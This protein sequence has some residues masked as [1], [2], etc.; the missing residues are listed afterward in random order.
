MILLMADIGTEFDR[1]PLK[2]AIAMATEILALNQDESCAPNESE[3]K[4]IYETYKPKVSGYLHAR[5]PCEADADD[6]VHDVFEKIY[7]KY[8]SFDSRKASISTWV[9]T[10]TRNTLV[11]YLRRYRPWEELYESIVS[12]E[13]VDDR[14]MTDELLDELAKALMLLPTDQKDLIVMRYCDR[15]P[16]TEI[17]ARID[18]S[19]G[20]V[21]IIHNKAL[22]TLREAMSTYLYETEETSDSNEEIII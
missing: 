10:I 7:K 6:L 14:L 11:D 19:Y 4:N 5:V 22:K 18:R 1:F 2:G 17:S 13:M 3:L 9:F 21:K 16:L 12:D 20:A 8:A 15:L